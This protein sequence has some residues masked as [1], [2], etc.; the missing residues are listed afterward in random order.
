MLGKVLQNYGSLTV[1]RVVS[2]LFQFALK[3]YLIRTTLD[4]DTLGQLVG[5]E[6]IVSTSLHVVKTSLKP[7][8][9]K[10]SD[11]KNIIKSAMN[12][13]TAGVLV[14]LLCSALV[15]LFQYWQYAGS[16]RHSA[17]YPHTILL[18]AASAVCE[19]VAEKY[20]VE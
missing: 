12:I 18:Y 17:Y 20:M 16:G 5:L 1:M 14:T 8:Y 15:G 9:Q 7:S 2:R 13:M 6:F 19:A 4:E 3:T 11:E 10:V